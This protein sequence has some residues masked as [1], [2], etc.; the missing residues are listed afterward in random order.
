MND[1]AYQQFFKRGSEGGYRLVSK[2]LHNGVRPG[3][4]YGTAVPLNIFL[5][6]QT[7]T[8][9]PKGKNVNIENVTPTQQAVEIARSELNR[10]DTAHDQQISVKKQSSKK[11][12][13]SKKKSSTS[14]SSSRK[15]PS[16]RKGDKELTELE[17]SVK[18]TKK[19]GYKKTS[20]LGN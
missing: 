13:H 1:K 11:K 14:K 5:N 9:L 6:T 7:E 15:Q 17:K 19:N 3:V 8:A 12:A 16:K 20:K 4:R 18:K 2:Y 10:E